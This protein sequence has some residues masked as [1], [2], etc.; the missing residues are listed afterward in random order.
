ML[1]YHTT[2]H[3]WKCLG[4]TVTL[5]LEDSIQDAICPKCHKKM[6]VFRW[7]GIDSLILLN[8]MM[9]VG[10]ST[11]VVIGIRKRV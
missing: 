1:A 7:F 2:M 4:C 8:V 9:Y 11:S 5:L 3:A 6:F 10:L